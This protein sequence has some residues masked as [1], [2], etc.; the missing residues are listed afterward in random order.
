MQLYL[1]LYSITWVSLIQLLYSFYC[2]YLYKCNTTNYIWF[3]SHMYRLVISYTMDIN[4]VLTKLFNKDTLVGS[5]KFNL[6]SD[7]KVAM[8]IRVNSV[9]LIWFQILQRNLMV[10]AMMDLL[11]GRKVH[12]MFLF[13]RSW[14]KSKYIL[15]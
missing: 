8:A 11:Q 5:S 4:H 14:W 1:N 6:Q 13:K 7:Q 9:G 3:F 12:F 10:D 15:L 2:Y